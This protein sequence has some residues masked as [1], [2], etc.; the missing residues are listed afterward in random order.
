MENIYINDLELL[1]NNPDFVPINSIDEDFVKSINEGNKNYNRTIENET[2]EKIILND[3]DKFENIIKDIYDNGFRKYKYSNVILFK[4]ENSN[5]YIVISG[6]EIIAA[7]K[8]MN[9]DDNEIDF[10]DSFAEYKQYKKE[11]NFNF[12]NSVELNR[13]EQIRDVFFNRFFNNQKNNDELNEKLKY[14]SIIKIF[15]NDKITQITKFF[16]DNK[17]EYERIFNTSAEKIDKLHEDACFVFDYIRFNV[18][19]SKYDEEKYLKEL[20]M[21]KNL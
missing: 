21:K 6:N 17:K 4:K 1:I 5:K 15:K 2:I 10:Y 11:I 20:K 12:N 13:N 9:N 18:F 7:L 14:I 3:K 8:L 16:E 19:N